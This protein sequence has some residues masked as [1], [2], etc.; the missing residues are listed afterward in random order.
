MSWG[1]KFF[2]FDEPIRWFKAIGTSPSNA[3]FGASRAIDTVHEQTLVQPGDQI[4]ALVGG[5]FL[6]RADGTVETGRLRLPKPHFE[7][8]H[9]GRD[10][11]ADLLARMVK[12]G[13]CKEISAPAGKIDYN[14][15]RVALEGKRLPDHMGSVT[16]EG[17]VRS[18]QLQALLDAASSAKL[19]KA[20]KDSG[21]EWFAADVGQGV[22]PDGLGSYLQVKLAGGGG[23]IEIRAT[24]LDDTVWIV[25]QKSGF[26]AAL[27]EA[28]AGNWDLNPEYRNELVTIFPEHETEV[29][30]DVLATYVRDG[31]IPQPSASAP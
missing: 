22:E 28:G 24:P 12:A 19:G 13:R 15:S 17:Y 11:D 25:D 6:V 7:K 8:S 9:G 2:E 31:Q 10:S 23:Q 14:A 30:L 21:S 29:L 1:N 18:P 5:T 3:Y 20:V 27:K 26:T 4:H 16:K